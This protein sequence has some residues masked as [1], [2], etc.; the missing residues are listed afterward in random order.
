MNIWQTCTESCCEAVVAFLTNQDLFGANKEQKNRINIVVFS[1]L[2]IRCIGA[3]KA[4]L[5]IGSH[6]TELRASRFSAI[7][8]RSG[9]LNM[10]ILSSLKASGTSGVCETRFSNCLLFCSQGKLLERAYKP[11]C[12]WSKIHKHTNTRE[13][14]PPSC[15]QFLLEMQEMDSLQPAGLQKSLAYSFYTFSSSLTSSSSKMTEEP[16]VCSHVHSSYLFLWKTASL[17]ETA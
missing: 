3:G 13:T 10:V 8:F 2:V 15:L 1:C 12:R 17:K 9:G 11:L 5:S 14:N 7:F 4:P 16:L 6:F